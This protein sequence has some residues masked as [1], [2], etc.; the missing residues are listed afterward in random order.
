LVVDDVETNLYVARGLMAPYG[1][2]IDTAVSGFEAVDKIRSGAKYDI[3]FMDHMM[4]KMDG[5]EAVKI[6]RSLEYTSPI[7]ALTANALAGHSEMFLANGFDGFISKPIDIRQL[8]ASLNKFIRD[9]QSSDVLEDA[10]KQKDALYASGKHR[11]AIE[12]QLAEIFVRDAEKAF[13][14]F[15]II[16]KNGFRRAD[17]ISTFIIN[18]H[19]MKSALANIGESVLSGEAEKLEQ[20]GRDEDTRLILSALPEFMESLQ[21]VIDK[22]KPVDD[23]NEEEMPATS[24]ADEQYLQEKLSKIHSAC[25]NFDKKTAKEAL[26]ELKAKTWPKPVRDRLSIIAEHLLH[27]EFNEAAAIADEKIKV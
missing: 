21:K 5:I 23:E 22:L 16:N 18:I 15:R 26:N 4:P 25:I 19:A 6:I 11:I 1:L 12:P 17:D 2:S 3:I 7:V 8:N 14:I 20:A 13:D 27:I 24:D 9:K 10:K